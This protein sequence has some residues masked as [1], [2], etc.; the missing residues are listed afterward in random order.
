[1]A[2]LHTVVVLRRG[3]GIAR[4]GGVDLYPMAHPPCIRG[5]QSISVKAGTAPH[6]AGTPASVAQMHRHHLI[7]VAR[8]DPHWRTH[9][10]ALHTEFNDHLVL[11]PKLC[12][13]ARTEQ[14]GVVPGEF[15]YGLGEF[16]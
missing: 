9:G 4:T 5:T 3:Q 13:G 1:M 12:S 6:P 14:G 2:P 8:H 16:L 10:A 15:R 11:Q 7:S